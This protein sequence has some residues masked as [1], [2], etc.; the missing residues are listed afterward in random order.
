VYKR[1]QENCEGIRI[2]NALDDKGKITF[3]LVGYN[4]ENND[5][6]DGKILDHIKLCPIYCPNKSPLMV[7]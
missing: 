5:M 7:S 4:K 3:V 2:Y 1:Q 6:V